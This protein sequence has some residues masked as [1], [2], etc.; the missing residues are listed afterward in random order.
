MLGT[1]FQYF[2]TKYANFKKK[3]IFTEY[4]TNRVCK[5]IL[6]SVFKNLEKSFRIKF[7]S[8]IC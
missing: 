5:L 8:M 6:A 4:F 1:F 2:D 7:C 3:K